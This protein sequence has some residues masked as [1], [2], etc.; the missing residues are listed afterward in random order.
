MYRNDPKLGGIKNKNLGLYFQNQSWLSAWVSSTN[1]V[2]PDPNPKDKKISPWGP[3]KCK[4][5]QLFRVYRCSSHVYWSLLSFIFSTLSLSF[6]QFLLNP[7]DL[8]KKILHFLVRLNLPFDS[9]KKIIGTRLLVR[10]VTLLW[11][12]REKKTAYMFTFLG[13][14][15]SKCD[16]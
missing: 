4:R 2:V 3:K 5:G 8:H 12:S 16:S 14:C 1:V 10:F 7:V 6:A 13:F 9:E 11:Y 15:F